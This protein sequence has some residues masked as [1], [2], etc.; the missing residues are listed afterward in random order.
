MSKPLS[1][2]KLRQDLKRALASTA[3]DSSDLRHGLAHAIAAIER[4]ES[5]RL[6]DKGAPS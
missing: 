2:P 4:Q 6:V 3:K 5:K 1:L